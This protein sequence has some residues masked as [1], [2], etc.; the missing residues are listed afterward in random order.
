[1]EFPC[2]RH[3]PTA[4]RPT[5]ED[6]GLGSAVPCVSLEFCALG[7]G[8]IGNGA[9]RCRM[10]HILVRPQLFYA[11]RGQS[12]LVVNTRGDCDADET[13]AGFYFRETRHL[14]TLRLS[15]NGHSP[16]L[17]ESASLDPATLHFGYVHPELTSFGGGGSGQAG[18]GITTD[19]DGIPHRALDLRLTYEVGTS[20]LAAELKITN[21]S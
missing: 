5:V 19:A 11:W 21:R 8:Q 17:C 1:M 15:V 4:N 10:A 2:I 6:A 14:R 20:Q 9:P 3:P 12:L 13:L 16:W 18:D 7:R